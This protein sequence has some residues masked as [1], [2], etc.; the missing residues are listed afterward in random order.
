MKLKDVVKDPSHPIM[1][2]VIKNQQTSFG[3]TL[4]CIRCKKEYKRGVWDFYMLCN[5]CFSLFDKQKMVGRLGTFVMGK[6]GLTWFENAEKWVEENP[7]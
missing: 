6:K 3:D 7:I 5:D 1:Q 4:V 2:G